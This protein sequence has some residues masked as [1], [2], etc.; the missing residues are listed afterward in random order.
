VQ[1]HVFL[2]SRSVV[3]LHCCPYLILLR[4]GE[5][6]TSGQVNRQDVTNNAVLHVLDAEDGGHPADGLAD[7]RDSRYRPVA[8]Q[9]TGDV[10]QRVDVLFRAVPVERPMGVKGHPLQVDMTA[11]VNVVLCPLGFL[12]QPGQVSPVVRVPAA[13]FL[14][15]ANKVALLGG[16]QERDASE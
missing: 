4:L 14:I 15:K 1:K 2:V 16:G 11:A 13:V 8:G 9:V 5:V 6:V 10:N 12:I 3:A 7:Q